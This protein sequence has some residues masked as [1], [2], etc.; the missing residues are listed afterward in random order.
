[1]MVERGVK[2]MEVEEKGR[3]GEEK[4]GEW[5]KCERKRGKQVGET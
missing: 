3:N 4:K 2:A 5:K 1:M